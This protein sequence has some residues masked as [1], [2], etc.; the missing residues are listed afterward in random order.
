[1]CRE[2]DRWRIREYA[3]GRGAETYLLDEFDPGSGLS[4]PSYRGMIELIIPVGGSGWRYQPDAEV[5]WA[6][7]DNYGQVVFKDV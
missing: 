7:W 2:C 4:N 1:M 5:D 6:H 3:A